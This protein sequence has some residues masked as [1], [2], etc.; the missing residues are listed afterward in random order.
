MVEEDRILGNQLTVALQ[1][2][3]VDGRATLNDFIRLPWSITGMTPCGYRLCF[4]SDGGTYPPA[5]LFSSMPA[6]SPG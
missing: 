6:I 2:V 4:S 5:I 1:I 3:E